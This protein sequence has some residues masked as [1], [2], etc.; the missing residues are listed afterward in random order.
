MSRM[1]L[2]AAILAACVAQAHGGAAA[3]ALRC[4]PGDQSAAINAGLTPGGALQIGPGICLLGDTIRMPSGATLSGAGPGVTVLRALPGSA[5]FNL[6][7]VGPAP[8]APAGAPPVSRVRV[9]G[10]T[11][12]G[13]AGAGSAAQKRGNGVM[14]WPGARGVQLADL[15]ITGNGDNGLYL[16]GHDTA[17]THS[18]IHDNWHNGIYVSGIA[19]SDA[20]PTTIS[21]NTVQR[22]SLQRAA[23]WHQT[24]PGEHAWDGID[25]GPNHTGCDI[26][27]NTV[28]GNDII[29]RDGG[30]AHSNGWSGHDRIIGNTVSGSGVACIDVAAH[31]DSFEVRQNHVGP[32]ALDGILVVGAAQN[33]TVSGNVVDGAGH[34]GIAVRGVGRS[35]SV[36]GNSVGRAGR[37]AYFVHG[38]ANV[39]LQGN[40]GGP[41]DARMAGPGLS[42]Q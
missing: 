26:E 13:A 17:I 39:T 35:I 5:P 11:L 30:T 12:D 31:I 18:R 2:T 15:E 20:G 8:G 23:G 19:A 29:V 38:T 4:G 25:C 10:L 1:V 22:N 16:M 6:I 41:I 21:G 7:E 34:A 37:A 33:G 36:V 28:L 40:A 3:A 9:S 42:M 24:H 14:V 27:G 32:C